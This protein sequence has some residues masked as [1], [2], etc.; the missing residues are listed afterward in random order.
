M[1]PS[2]SQATRV[3]LTPGFNPRHGWYWLYIGL[4]TGLL[5][6]AF[7]SWHYDDPFITYRYADNLAHGLGFVYNEGE[8]VLSTTTPL[9]A[10]LL[11][12]LSH[13]WGDLPHLANLIGAFS[14][15]VGGV[16]FWQLAGSWAVPA[17]GW[18]GL[19]LYPTSPLLLTTLGSEMPLFLAFCLGSFALYARRSFVL[20]A[21]FAGLATLTRPDGLLVV[22][23]LVADYLIKE[24]GRPPWKAALLF[25]GLTLPWVVFAWSYFGSPLPATLAAK[26]HQ[27]SMLISPPF[28][29]RLPVILSSYASHWYYWLAALLAVAGVGAMVVRYR[30]W[31]LFIL[32][33]VAHFAV[34]TALGVSG[35]YW[36]YAPLV[37][38]FIAC[39]GLG[40]ALT[41]APLKH[42]GG[43][44]E[45]WLTWT[46]RCFV[47]L[48]VLL[49]AVL[50][51]GQLSSLW[52]LR[53]QPDSRYLIYR[54]I[55]EWLQGHTP[56]A[57]RVGTLEAGIIGYNTSRSM[58]DFAG[59]IQPQ[60]AAQLKPSSTYADAAL[61]AVQA[62]RPQYLVLLDGMFPELEGDYV[63]QS[64]QVSRHFKGKDYGFSGDLTIYTCEAQ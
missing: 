25:L 62:Y 44:T 58:V 19:F 48:P 52:H 32:W 59:L 39:L 2:T 21:A 49:I 36:Y 42:A 33:P 41:E 46:R 56:P 53:R 43:Q 22:F 4:V 12:I 24:R 14:L 3:P 63:S 50:A 64:C 23:L 13:F 17:V 26:Q 16:F 40:I 30:R 9:F 10:I 31:A 57:A 60:V 20:A 11:A 55:G 38:G 7:Y 37:P 6:V 15:A 61:F 27:G 34:Y 28:A 5:F 1:H 35:Y 54:A 51:A 45:S 47:L 29:T 18:A 8:R